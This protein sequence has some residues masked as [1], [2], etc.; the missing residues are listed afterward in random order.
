MTRQSRMLVS[1]AADRFEVSRSVLDTAI[2]DEKLK[3]RVEIRSDLNNRRVQTLAFAETRDFVRR[4][5]RHEKKKTENEYVTISITRDEKKELEEL[6]V[7]YARRIT[8]PR[9]PR[10]VDFLMLAARRYVETS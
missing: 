7:E 1:E 4:V 10:L 3:T 9:K 5:R 6:R 2:R 8:R